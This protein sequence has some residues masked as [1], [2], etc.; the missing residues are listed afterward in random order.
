MVHRVVVSEFGE[1]FSEPLLGSWEPS[2]GDRA[3][4]AAVG[5]STTSCSFYDEDDGLLSNLICVSPTIATSSKI[6]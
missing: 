5:P 2:D 4:V 1:K 6:Q 3:L